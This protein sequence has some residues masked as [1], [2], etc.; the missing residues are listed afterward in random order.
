[1]TREYTCEG[2]DENDSTATVAMS[3]P[4][5]LVLEAATVFGWVSGSCV[6]TF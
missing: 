3:G 5:I 4:P 1:M 6:V 2:L